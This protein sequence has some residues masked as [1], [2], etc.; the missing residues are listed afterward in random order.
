MATDILCKAV[1]FKNPR[2]STYDQRA[3]DERD[4]L[5]KPKAAELE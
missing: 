2:T 3:V 5:S 4:Y 1:S